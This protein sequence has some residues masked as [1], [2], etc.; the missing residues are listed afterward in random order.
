M[1]TFGKGL[2]LCHNMGKRQRTGQAEQA[3]TEKRDKGDWSHSVATALSR[4]NPLQ[5]EMH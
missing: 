1:A 4:I 5:C 3:D 2:M